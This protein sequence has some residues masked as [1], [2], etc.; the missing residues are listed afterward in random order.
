MVDVDGINRIRQK[1]L[2]TKQNWAK[3]GR[4]L[5]PN[6]GQEN[7]KKSGGTSENRLPRLPP[8]QHLVQNWPVLDLGIVPKIER[9]DW[10][11]KIVGLVERPMTW[12][13][14]DL[15]GQPQQESI[16]DIHCVT[17][18]SRYDNRWSGVMARHIIDL[19][20]PLANARHLIFTSYDNYTTNV[21]LE[22]F[23]EEDVLLAHSWQGEPLTV[24]HGAPLRVIMPKYYFWKSAKWIKQIE[25]IA[26]DKPGY[27]ENRGY[28]MV[29]D[30]W[31]ED[32]YDR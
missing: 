27:W 4:F 2:D 28:H 25:F 11:L 20:K 13:W 1:L 21:R 16:S 15:M 3:E 24:E 17:T 32:R 29:G 9:S 19:V 5:T 8:G 23:A 12:S 30:P 10:R 22:L 26:D 14:H 18:W 7:P 31:K 6:A